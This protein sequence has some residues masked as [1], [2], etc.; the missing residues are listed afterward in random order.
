MAT[1]TTNYKF[2]KPALSEPAD[3]AVINTD[4]DLIDTALKKVEDSVPEN[5]A[6]SNT[7][8]GSAYSANKIVAQDIG[9]MN[10]KTITQLK[11]ALDTWLVENPNYMA[12]CRFRSSYN[13]TTLWNANDTT[14]T[15][16][17]GSTWY[18]TKIGGYSDNLYCQLLISTYDD[19]IVYTVAK[20]NGTWGRVLKLANEDYVSENYAAKSHTHPIDSALSITS[21]NPVQNKVVAKVIGDI[22]G[23]LSAVI[24]GTDFDA[25]L[26]D[27]LGV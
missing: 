1:Q 4:L 5:Y 24:N 14:T 20:V 16:N 13:W 26:T 10:G 7:A 17:A 27:L 19:G 11:T 21:E 25:Q 23:A 2:T 3:I 18:V 15:V 12:V 6:G 8:G 22:D 9:S